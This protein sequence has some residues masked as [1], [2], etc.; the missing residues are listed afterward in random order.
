MRFLIV[1]LFYI[2]LYRGGHTNNVIINDIPVLKGE[3]YDIKCP[4]LNSHIAYCWVLSPN[5][6][7]FS[8]SPRVTNLNY[9]YTGAGFAAG[10]CGIRIRSS[11]ITDNGLW[12]C[13]MGNLDPVDYVAVFNVSVHDTPLVAK[14]KMVLLKRSTN[15][16]CETN[17]NTPLEYCRYVR[18][19]GRGIFPMSESSTYSD[20]GITLQGGRCSLVFLNPTSLDLG[21]WTC[22]AKPITDPVEYFDTILIHNYEYR[23]SKNAATSAI[24]WILY[25]LSVTAIIVLSML[26]LFKL[27]IDSRTSS[28]ARP[29]ISDSTSY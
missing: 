24:F 4:S 21:N 11:S 29:V 26:I 6:T 3:T 14:E 16:T 2:T 18:P 7:I 1:F 5:G 25:I 19:D 20:F 10:E 8:L 28:Q 15:I 17:N 9:N 27:R 22:I 23:N 13:N 12:K